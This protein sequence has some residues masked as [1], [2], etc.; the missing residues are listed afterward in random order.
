M[1]LVGSGGKKII[2]ILIPEHFLR[3]QTDRHIALACCCCG[4]LLYLWLAEVITVMQN[5]L[6][7]DQ[8]HRA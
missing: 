5:M 4:A 8:P 1:G 6:F 2:P 7:Q 3:V